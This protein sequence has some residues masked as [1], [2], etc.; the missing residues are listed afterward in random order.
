MF[1]IHLTRLEDY[2]NQWIIV[3]LS[4]TPIH[5]GTGFGFMLSPIQ[6]LIS[7]DDYLFVQLLK[8]FLENQKDM[9]VI[10]CQPNPR[11]LESDQNFENNLP[12]ILLIEIKRGNGNGLDMI[13][14]FTE[15]CPLLKVVI[16]TSDYRETYIGSLFRYGVHGL[17]SKGISKEDLLLVIRDVAQKGFY[18]SEE[19]LEFLRHQISQRIPLPVS[20]STDS[21][22][23]REIEILKLIGHQYTAKEIG[24]KLHLSTRTVETHKS[25]LFIK[26]GVKN[27]AG[28][29]IYGVKNHFIHPEEIVLFD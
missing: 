17:V 9:I 11:Y 4:R 27:I 25:N 29:I 22:S 15:K 18:L 20:K 21:L 12:Q 14:S 6:I 19:Q 13:K 8:G 23:D 10:S 24:Q 5:P 1:T 3:Q 26:T 16:L 28:L 7:D 2:G